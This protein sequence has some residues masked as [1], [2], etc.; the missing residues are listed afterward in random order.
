MLALR[1][2]DGESCHEVSVLRIRGRPRVSKTS[3]GEGGKKER[4]MR[5]AIY[6]RMSTENQN[7]RSP[8]DKV[9]AR[10]PARATALPVLEY[11]VE[12]EL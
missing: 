10:A 12:I 4:N 9:A 3:K 6:A 11:R 5:A 2:M 1:K 7:E 8:D